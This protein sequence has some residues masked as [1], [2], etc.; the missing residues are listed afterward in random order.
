MKTLLLALV[1]CSILWMPHAV[2]QDEGPFSRNN[3]SRLVPSASFEQFLVTMEMYKDTLGLRK[4][5]IEVWLLMG[6]PQVEDATGNLIVDSEVIMNSIHDT[7]LNATESDSFISLIYKDIADHNFREL[8]TVTQIKQPY[9]Y[10]VAI[11]DSTDDL[12][13]TDSAIL[14][15]LIECE[16][17]TVPFR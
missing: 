10:N 16:A 13:A 15:K 2:A 5:A 3:M 9:I 12:G 14:Q 6:G 4:L 7:G 11:R 17:I 8:R 1:V